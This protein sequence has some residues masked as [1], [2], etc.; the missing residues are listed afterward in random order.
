MAPLIR[1]DAIGLWCVL[2]ILVVAA[3]TVTLVTGGR[4]GGMGWT[5]WIL[6]YPLV[7]CG[8][9]AI[10]L[11]RLLPD[12]R[13]A[14]IVATTCFALAVVVVLV[15]GVYLMLLLLFAVVPLSMSDDGASPWFGVYLSALALGSGAL[16][17]VIQWRLLRRSWDGTHVLVPVHALLVLFMS[18]WPP[19][20]DALVLW[21]PQLPAT[22]SGASLPVAAI[23]GLAVAAG[24][25]W[26]VLRL[27]RRTDGQANLST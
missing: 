15:P 20:W 1:G 8:L 11:R 6:Y 12:A 7:V 27:D 21:L 16:V 19:A 3:T 24:S 4:S 5:L 17:G 14:T 9:Q 18:G 23:S 10:F 25:G 2:H 22:A 13:K 26:T